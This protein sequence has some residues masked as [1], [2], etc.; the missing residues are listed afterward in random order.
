MGNNS[1]DQGLKKNEHY[2]ENIIDYIGDP[3]FVKDEQS[4]ILLV[5][6]AFC[7]IFSLLNS[8]NS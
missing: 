1:V 4:K 8:I 3:V 2:F 5:N 6:D 7:S